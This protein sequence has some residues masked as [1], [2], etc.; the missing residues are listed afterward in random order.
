MLNV[1]EVLSEEQKGRRA[2]LRLQGTAV[3]V[4]QIPIWNDERGMLE[5][6]CIQRD[7]QAS[8]ESLQLGV[9]F[10]RPLRQ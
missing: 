6:E 7:R 5:Q 8:V 1:A 9:S 3:T 2:H 10:R 4:S